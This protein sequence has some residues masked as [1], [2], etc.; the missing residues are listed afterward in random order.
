MLLA[1]G[2]LPVVA[3]A[4]VESLY[5]TE[6]GL[7]AALVFGAGEMLWEW[8]K[9]G[10]IQ[11]FTLGSNALV[12][13]LGAVSL[14]EGDG[15]WFKLQ[16]T[17]IIGIFGAVLLASS[18]MGK[19]LLFELAKKQNPDLPEIARVSLSGLNFRLSLVLFGLAAF[20]VHV[21][22]EWSTAAW[23]IF[24]GVGVPAVLLPYFFVEIVILRKGV[25][26]SK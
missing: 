7:I 23:A 9:Y 2:L 17:M 18:L 5:G 14:W 26:Q 10:K 24:K 1:G 21:A 12:L 15:L 11:K 6:G 25:S 13:V 16:P 8:R 22:L 3:F 20:S 19:P 4:V